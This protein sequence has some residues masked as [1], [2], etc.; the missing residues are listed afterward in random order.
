MGGPMMGGAMMGGPMMGGPMM[1][2]FYDG[3][4]HV[5]GPRMDFR[6]TAQGQQG[7]PPCDDG[8]GFG[9][10]FVKWG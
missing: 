8:R 2:A 10:P 1:G 4:P 7:P 9:G 5:G 6:P 3:R